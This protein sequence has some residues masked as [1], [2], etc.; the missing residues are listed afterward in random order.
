[1]EQSRALFRSGRGGHAADSGGKRP[2]NT[3]AASRFEGRGS[4]WTSPPDRTPAQ[5][6]LLQLDEAL[7][8]LESRDALA[9]NLVKLRFFAGLSMAQAASALGLPLRTAERN[10]TYARSWL[11]R[12]LAQTVD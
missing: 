11:H 8:R 12:E 9:A 5:S 6:E 2:Q 7:Q 1:M 10:W 3:A 4:L